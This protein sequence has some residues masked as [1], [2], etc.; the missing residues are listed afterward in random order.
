MMNKLEQIMAQLSQFQ[1]KLDRIGDLP[2]RVA[3]LE[4]KLL[5]VSNIYHYERL[6][7][8]LKYLLSLLMTRS[9]Y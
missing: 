6:Q 7:N 1:P 9:K 8:L 5:R 2:E 3:R 4:E